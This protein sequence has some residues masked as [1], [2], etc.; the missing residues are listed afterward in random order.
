MCNCY[1]VIDELKAQNQY[2]AECVGRMSEALTR[3]NPLTEK[4]LDRYVETLNL[5]SEEHIAHER[6]EY[7]SAR[8][9]DQVKSLESQNTVLNV[10]LE[11]SK[12]EVRHLT[13]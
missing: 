8:A 7:S 3:P 11:E 4:L 13:K 1:I 6:A 10:L 5:L 12:D 2:L 9:W